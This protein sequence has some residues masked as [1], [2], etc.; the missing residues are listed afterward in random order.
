MSLVAHWF[1]SEWVPRGGVDLSLAFLSEGRRFEPCPRQ[2]WKKLFQ[3]ESLDS[4]SREWDNNTCIIGAWHNSLDRSP[5]WYLVYPLLKVFLSQDWSF[6]TFSSRL[7]ECAPRHHYCAKAVCICSRSSSK[8][9]W[10]SKRRLTKIF[11]LLCRLNFF[12][13]AAFLLRKYV[14]LFLQE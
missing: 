5:P 4:H 13:K 2:F 10:S 9:T 8:L 6:W 1:V 11:S 7:A 12:L 14:L 3:D